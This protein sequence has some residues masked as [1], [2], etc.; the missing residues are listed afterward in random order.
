MFYLRVLQ[1]SATTG[2][3]LKLFFNDNKRAID[4]KDFES[5]CKLF[6]DDDAFFAY[7]NN[8]DVW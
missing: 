7:E 4:V 8:G 2:K 1:A 3:D 5:Y 6:L